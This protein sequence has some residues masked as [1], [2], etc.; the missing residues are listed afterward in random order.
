MSDTMKRASPW[1]GHNVGDG[2]EFAIVFFLC[3][4]WR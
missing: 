1:V 3:W 4:L 2:V